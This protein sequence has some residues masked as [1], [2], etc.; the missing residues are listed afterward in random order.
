MM[1]NRLNGMLKGAFLGDAIALGPHWIYDVAKIKEV[2]GEISGITP[3]Q[4]DSFHKGKKRGDWTHYGE[5]TLM[6]MDYLSGQKG[7]EQTDFL[8]H[9]DAFMQTYP[10]YKDHATKETLANIAKGNWEGSSSNEL[11]GTARMVAPLY[12]FAQEEEKAISAAGSQ[13]EAT[14]RDSDLLEITAFLAK[15]TL[16][17]L[18]GKHPIETLEKQLPEHS[19]YLQ[20]RWRAAQEVLALEAEEAIPKLGQMCNSRNAFPSVLYLLYKYE[21][22]FPLTLYK[23]AQAGGDSAARGMVLGTILGAWTGEEGLPQALLQE[24]NGYPALLKYC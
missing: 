5:Q 3:P 17:V 18:S 9:F 20:E 6:L 12:F 4:P 7:F 2:F 1:K 14:H 19:I 22:A 10:G 21:L 23:N 13:C 11:G 15:L 24:M 8:Q 16:A